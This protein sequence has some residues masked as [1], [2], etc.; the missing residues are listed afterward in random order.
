[1]SERPVID[2]NTEHSGELETFMHQTLRPVMKQLNEKFLVLAKINLKSEEIKF[3]L[4]QPF[5]KEEKVNALVSTNQPFKNT[6][7]GMVIG[8]FSETEFEFYEKNMREI[9]KRIAALLRER[10]ASQLHNL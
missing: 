5:E 1:M 10:L 6:V 8:L 3:K 9:N 2:V 7:S 4:L